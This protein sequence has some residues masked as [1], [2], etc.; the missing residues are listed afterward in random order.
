[1]ALDRTA[2]ATAPGGRDALAGDDEAAEASDDTAKGRR[3][4]V[5]VGLP[6]A[7]TVWSIGAV[8][9]FA[10]WAVMTFWLITSLEAINQ[11]IGVLA[12]ESTEQGSGGEPAVE[13]LTEPVA[14]EAESAA[15][16][17]AAPEPAITAAPSPTSEPAPLTLFGKLVLTD[18]ADLWNCIDFQNWEEA[19]MVY[20][21]NLPDDPNLIDFDGNGVPCESLRQQD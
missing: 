6:A 11:S 7:K 10:T 2:E 5:S 17:V 20:E 15:E 12:G 13:T 21:A 14:T 4:S 8:I 9:A 3:L 18:G 16:T 1:M 19:S